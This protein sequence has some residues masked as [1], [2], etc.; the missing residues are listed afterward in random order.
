MTAERRP[1]AGPHAARRGGLVIRIF[2][3]PKED[4]NPGTFR[5]GDLKPLESNAE[6]S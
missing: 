6:E 1:A 2:H 4:A 5:V 3:T